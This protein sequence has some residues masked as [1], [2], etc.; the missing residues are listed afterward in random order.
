MLKGQKESSLGINKSNPKTA[1]IAHQVIVKNTRQWLDQ[2][3]LGLNLNLFSFGVIAQDQVHYAICDAS[4]DVD[5]KQFYVTELERLLDADEND[6][7][8]SLLIFIQGLE[9]FDDYLDLLDWCKKLLEQADLIEH[10]QLAYFH[11]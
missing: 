10:M 5:C 11:P 9:M 7:A 4:N 6:T 1:C 2:M 8:T 3:V